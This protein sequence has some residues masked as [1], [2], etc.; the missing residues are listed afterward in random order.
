MK[1]Y[2]LA[3]IAV[4][5]FASLIY[6][7][8][9]ME[10]GV[11]ARGSPHFCGSSCNSFMDCEFGVCINAVC[12]CPSMYLCTENICVPNG[13]AEGCNIFDQC[14][15]NSDCG[16]GYLCSVDCICVK[17]SGGGGGGGGGGTR[18]IYVNDSNETPTIIQNYYTV[19]TNGTQ[20]LGNTSSP[21]IS[22]SEDELKGKVNLPTGSAIAQQ[23]SENTVKARG[24]LSN[25]LLLQVFIISITGITLYLIKVNFLKRRRR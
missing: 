23:T 11:Y 1:K 19:Y 24:D 12:N 7:S 20:G 21:T 9:A 13:G 15:S 5:V 3:T 18:T 10:T 8:F 4:F 16:S 6:P 25:K 2:L 17:T 14:D 22:I